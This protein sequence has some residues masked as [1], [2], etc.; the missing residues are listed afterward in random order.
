MD[1]VGVSTRGKVEKRGCIER[2]DTDQVPKK[3]KPNLSETLKTQRVRECDAVVH[4]SHPFHS[5]DLIYGRVSY[6]PGL[7]VDETQ[8]RP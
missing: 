1:A 3:T 5:V 2:P 7:L 8:P 4:T 6:R